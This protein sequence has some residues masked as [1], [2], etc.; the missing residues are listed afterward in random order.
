MFLKTVSEVFLAAAG[1]AW[2]AASALPISQTT[3]ITAAAALNDHARDQPGGF[4]RAI[5]DIM[6]ELGA[7]R[8]KPLLC[9]RIHA[10]GR[11][12]LKADAVSGQS[13]QMRSFLPFPRNAHAP[14]TS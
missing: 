7:L 1:R 4:L 12:R 9:R 2:G 8:V 13:G 5:G 10:T 14:Y 11:P 3:A 6:T